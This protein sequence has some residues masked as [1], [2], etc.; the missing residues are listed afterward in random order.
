MFQ[1]MTGH[2]FSSKQWIVLCSKIKMSLTHSVSDSVTRSPI[3]LFWTAKN[4]LK[5]D[6]E[7]ANYILKTK[8]TQGQKS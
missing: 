1:P 6:D 2:K 8:L 7:E 3:E 5:M 4:N